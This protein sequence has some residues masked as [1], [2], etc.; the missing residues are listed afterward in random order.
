MYYICISHIR[1]KQ[2]S[3]NAIQIKKSNIPKI[4]SSNF[5]WETFLMPISLARAWYVGYNWKNSRRAA[6]WGF[7]WQQSISCSSLKPIMVASALRLRVSDDVSTIYSV[8][9]CVETYDERIPQHPLFDSF[10][11]T[12]SAV[13]S[14]DVVWF[15]FVSSSS[16]V[17]SNNNRHPLFY[18]FY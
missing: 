9:A 12:L 7:G 18:S 3:Q 11:N 8:L 13:Y 6:F 17:H 14:Y 4:S 2:L 16:S 15:I 5:D 10:T 1:I